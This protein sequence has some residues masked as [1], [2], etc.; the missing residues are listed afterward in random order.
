LKYKLL[1]QIVISNQSNT[2]A[3]AKGFC[4]SGLY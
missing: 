4:C 2:D 1:S 3:I